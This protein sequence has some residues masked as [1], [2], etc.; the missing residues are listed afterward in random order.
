MNVLEHIECDSSA[1]SDVNE[2]DDDFNKASE[3]DDYCESLHESDIMTGS[4]LSSI[5]RSACLESASNLSL[6][7]SGASFLSVLKGPT[8]SDLS[9]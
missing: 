8:K 4:T 2:V 3:G 1:E 6:S 7:T 9:C 5:S